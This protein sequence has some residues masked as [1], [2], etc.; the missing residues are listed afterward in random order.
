MTAKLNPPRAH[1]FGDV[2][3]GLRPKVVARDLNLATNLPMSVIGNADPTRLGD[4]FETHCNIDTITKDIVV[5][6]M[7]SPT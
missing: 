4:P 1:W 7:I 5:A 3:E 2:L 6:M